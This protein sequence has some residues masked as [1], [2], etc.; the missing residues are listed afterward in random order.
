M[1]ASH[2][3]CYERVGEC[4]AKRCDFL[5]ATAFFTARRPFKPKM[6][7]LS[8]ELDKRSDK[9]SK[10]NSRADRAKNASR[11]FSKSA[12]EYNNA[13]TC[14][15]FADAISAVICDLFQ[16]CRPHN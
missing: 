16:I 3:G 5:V 15:P 14:P 2:I 6:Q 7:R 4:A 9:L 8:K 11:S 10:I 12:E 13:S 1:S